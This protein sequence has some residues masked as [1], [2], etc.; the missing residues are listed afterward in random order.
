ME[1]DGSA[2]A[3]ILDCCRVTGL[4]LET[5]AGEEGEV[6]SPDNGRDLVGV[7]CCDG[8]KPSGGRFLEPE[9]G[10]GY[11]GDAEGIA[12]VI[13]VLQD[14]EEFVAD[15]GFEVVAYAGAELACVE[16]DGVIVE[17]KD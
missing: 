7:A 10:A 14:V 3:V 12:R 4:V 17:A 2:V 1:E 8:L 5:V 6:V 9:P 13:E 16:R 11:F 15:G